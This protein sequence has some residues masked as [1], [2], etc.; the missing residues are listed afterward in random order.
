MTE[1]ADYLVV[2]AGIIGR[3]IAREL[4]R[5]HPKASVLLIDKEHRL[6]VHASGR[7]SGVLHAGFYYTPDSLKARLTRDGNARLTDYI[8]KRDLPI[9]HCGKLVVTRGEH[10]MKELDELFRRAEHNGVDV[11]EVSELQTR[12]IEPRAKTVRRALFSPST[13]TADPGVVLQAMADDAA[14]EGIRIELGKPYRG[15][16]S[17]G[18]MVGAD[19]VSVGHVVNAAGLYADRVA[20]D[21]GFGR[22]YCILPFK[23]LYLHGD[24]P[25]GSFKTNIYPVPDLANPFLGV[26]VTVT[27]D[28]HAKIGPTAIPAFWRE[29]YRRFENFSPRELVDVTRRE[30]GLLI[31]AGF[32][33]RRLAIR[34]L[35]KYRRKHLIRLAGS[36]ASDIDPG[37]YTRWGPSGIRAQLLD[38]GTRQLVT[39]FIIEGDTQSTHVL[40]AVSPG[41]T[42]ALPFAGTVV[43]RIDAAYP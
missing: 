15:V 42:C 35:R 17:N 25:A 4:K 34:E 16:R 26:H 2:G 13:A 24:E 37:R 31:R 39:D 23:G 43:D 12:R 6:G 29:H 1:T 40:N 10:E 7:N 38:I 8:T 20:R 22:R 33:F 14:S 41:W 3:S 9:N 30:L 36:L 32:D 28:G 18:A 27:V 21:F 5:R 11:E 19:V